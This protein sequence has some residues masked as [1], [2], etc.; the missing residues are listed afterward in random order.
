VKDTK[1]S[2][3]ELMKDGRCR[4]ATA[5]TSAHKPAEKGGRESIGAGQEGVVAG[6][7]D[8]IQERS[9]V[10]PGPFHAGA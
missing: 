4:K 7:R 5:T 8:E 1:V 10:T 9:A 2:K 6:R 3:D